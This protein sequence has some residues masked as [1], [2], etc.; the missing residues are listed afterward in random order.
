MFDKP[1]VID[2]TE[3]NS[4]LTPIQKTSIASSSYNHERK[5]VGHGYS[6]HDGGSDSP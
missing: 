5:H 3:I 1:L 2:G 4:H 6:L